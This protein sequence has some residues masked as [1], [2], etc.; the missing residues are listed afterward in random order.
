AAL[1]NRVSITKL[2]DR[3]YFS[4]EVDMPVILL[5]DYPVATNEDAV[6]RFPEVRF[7]LK[8]SRL[9]DYGPYLHFDLNYVNFT[10]SGQNYDDLTMA[11]DLLRPIGIGP[12]GEILRDGSYDPATDLFR[13]GQRLDTITS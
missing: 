12:K 3:F 10:R 8:D 1:T 4:G 13:T 2:S 6:N 5:K 11:G 9:F 7:G